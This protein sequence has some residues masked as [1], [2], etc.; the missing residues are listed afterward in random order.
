[1]R[2]AVPCAPACP[3]PQFPQSSRGP[4]PVRL[5][6]IYQALNERRVLGEV[7]D[8]CRAGAAVTR[9]QT[10]TSRGGKCLAQWGP[11]GRGTGASREHQV[12]RGCVGRTAERGGCKALAGRRD[13][14]RTCGPSPGVSSLLK[15]AVLL[16]FP[17]AVVEYKS[18]LRKEELNFPY[19][20]VCRPSWASQGSK[21]LKQLATLHPQP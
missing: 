14:R 10:Q 19:N 5:V 7:D 13:P 3:G 21:S 11:W 1:M 15:P 20:S 12:T 8:R 18:N 17:V 4:G 16:S 9:E 6:F 2:W